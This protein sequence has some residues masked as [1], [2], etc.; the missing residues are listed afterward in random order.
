MT[1]AIIYDQSPRTRATRMSKYREKTLNKEKK[2]KKFTR[3]IIYI[4]K[5][6]NK[7]AQRCW[8]EYGG[9]K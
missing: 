5:T 9:E 3:K 1:K 7:P 6:V 4:K 2:A 8:N